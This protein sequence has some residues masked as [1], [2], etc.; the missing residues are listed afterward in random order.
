MTI[1][2]MKERKRELGYSYEQLAELAGIPCSTV[3]KIFG[4]TTRSP[5]RSTI[6]SLERVLLPSA[7][8]AE[9]EEIQR[10][11]AL[12]EK[13]VSDRYL[14]DAGQPGVLREPGGVYHTSLNGKEKYTVTDYFH[15]PPERGRCELIDG[16]LY[17]MASPNAAHQGMSLRLGAL[18][19][20]YVDGH[21]GDC[22]VFTAPFDVI[23][24]PSD[25]HTVVQPDVMIIC[26]PSKIGKGYCEGP[27]DLVVEILSPANSESKMNEK[28]LK[29]RDAG[30]P[31]Y[32]AVNYDNKSI[33][34]ILFEDTEGNA[35]IHFYTFSDKVPVSIFE[36][37]FIDF[38]E[39]DAHVQ[40]YIDKCEGRD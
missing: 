11:K 28:M 14:Y 8:A 35:Q 27:P 33:T 23:P 26:D 25:R 30:V 9:K 31:E 21:G 29:Y 37:C 15:F 5:R 12:S 13:Y 36:D 2:E 40:K 1:Q 4:G 39:I 38:A 22:R 7:P 17:D 3:Q 18:F 6:E 32:W 16:V 24:D 20:Q 19:L 10:E 34:V